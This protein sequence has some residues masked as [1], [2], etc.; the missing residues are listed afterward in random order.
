MVTDYK[1]LMLCIFLSC[2]MHKIVVLMLFV[3]VWVLMIV[4][5]IYSDILTFMIYWGWELSSKYLLP[6]TST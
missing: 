5:C 3:V 2:R 1:K 6:Q 4:L